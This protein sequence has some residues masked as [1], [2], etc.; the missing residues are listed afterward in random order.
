MQLETEK[1]ANPAVAAGR[2]GYNPKDRVT[3]I[4]SDSHL[5]SAPGK[6]CLATD[7]LHEMLGIAFAFDFDLRQRL[8]YLVEIGL[9]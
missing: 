4:I 9:G 1:D 6:Q 8:L 5:F 3:G 7:C 2:R